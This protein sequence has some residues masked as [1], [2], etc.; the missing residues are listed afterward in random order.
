MTVHGGARPGAGR[1]AG[2]K[3]KATIERELRT[4][5]GVAAAVQ[6]G[7]LP[8]DVMLARMRDEALPNGMKPTDE[9][10]AAAVAAAP[11]LH[12]RLTATT[13]QGDLVV[14]A[15]DQER[16]RELRQSLMR[17]LSEL[18]KPAPLLEGATGA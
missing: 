14:S 11:Y 6:Q 17:E 9:Q 8:L 5:H 2:G 1:K 18:A 13:L 7:L 3:N 15:A 4:R 16:R 10:F 12:P